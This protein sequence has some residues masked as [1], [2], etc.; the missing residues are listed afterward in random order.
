MIEIQL[1]EGIEDRLTALAARK[2]RTKEYYVQSAIIDLVE[3]ME[4]PYLQ[5][6]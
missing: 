1:P 2:G 6:D 4:R 3:D 5:E